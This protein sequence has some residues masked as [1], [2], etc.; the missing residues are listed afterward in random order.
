MK[1]EQKID[2]VRNML[3]A[4]SKEG[5]MGGFNEYPW[6]C[7]ELMFKILPH[8]T[9]KGLEIILKEIEESSRLG[10]KRENFR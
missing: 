5:L 7:E 6:F 3:H 1:K 4:L 9:N 8:I 10:I 2:M